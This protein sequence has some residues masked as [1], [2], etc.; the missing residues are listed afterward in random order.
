MTI[1]S[2]KDLHVSFKTDRGLQPVLC[3]VDLDVFQGEAL[4][5]VG[6]SGSGKSVTA[7]AVL[8]LLGR[9]GRYIKGEI[10][11]KDTP[12]HSK[13]QK[14]MKAIRGK[15]IGMIYQ[16][17][18]TSLN[19]TLSI[20]W[21][22]AEMLVV[23]DGVS[24]RAARLRT[25]ELLKRVGIADA[26]HRYDAYPFQLSG[27]MRQRVLIAMA[28]ACR[29]DL[30]IADEPTTALD[31]TIQAQILEL[32]RQIQQEMGMTLLLITHDLAIVASLCTRVAVMDSGKIVEVGT[33][34]HLF[35][36]PQHPCTMALLEAKQRS[37]IN[38]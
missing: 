29:P 8:Q 17:P 38:G 24:R 9:S 10:F 33:V 31:V 15:K 30:L 25:M 12:L 2:I 27:G 20:G 34:D 3:G 11:F 4:A 21:Q 18:M 26:A 19:P 14:E 6:E 35:Y 22:I 36:S 1:L 16:D 13:S 28:L 37:T 23:H 7:Q 32:L 5:L